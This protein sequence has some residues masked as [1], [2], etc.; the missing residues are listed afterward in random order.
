[1]SVQLSF[2]PE[3]DDD[4]LVKMGV[5]LGE[6]NFSYYKNKTYQLSAQY[7]DGN[8]SS[9]TIFLKDH[10]D[11]WEPDKHNLTIRQKMTVTQPSFLFG[12]DGVARKR[13]TL[14][15]GAIWTC[16][17][18]NHRGAVEIC[19]F[20]DGGNSLTPELELKFPEGFLQK[21]L[22]IQIV[23][24]VKESAEALSE[25]EEALADLP[26]T[27]LGTINRFN[28]VIEGSGSIFPIV[29]VAENDK[30]LW[31]IVCSWTDPQEDS[32]DEENVKLCINTAHK[33]YKHVYDGKNVRN[34][35]V[36][37]EIMGS[38]LEIIIN[39]TK[40]SECWTSL[41]QNHNNAPGSIGE[42]VYYFID[43]FGWEY[44]DPQRLSTSIREYLEA[45]M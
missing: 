5:Q 38:A 33:N 43:T 13:S 1:M 44:Q 45:N 10:E 40:C 8:K 11:F 2:Y 22:S 17:S 32:F 24:Y 28:V 30:P 31:W 19:N 9:Q 16:K 18:S 41:I 35:P 20:T 15:M 25:E 37:I 23:I 21:E 6:V 26:G 36:F 3:I 27:I 4:L 39:R 29:E 34:S 7:P 42:A 12:S 14:G